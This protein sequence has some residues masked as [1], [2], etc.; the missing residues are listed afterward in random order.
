MIVKKWIEVEDECFGPDKE[1]G[2]WVMYLFI[3]LCRTIKRSNGVEYTTR[4]KTL[5]VLQG[6][7]KRSL[8]QKLEKYMDTKDTCLL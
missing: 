2:G 4:K 7:T 8:L 6:N 5:E 1:N 3:R